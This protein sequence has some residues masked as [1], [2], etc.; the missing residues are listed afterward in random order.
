MNE[1]WERGIKPA[2]RNS[3]TGFNISVPYGGTRQD[4]FFCPNVEITK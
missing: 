4:G 2:F 3:D 1:Q